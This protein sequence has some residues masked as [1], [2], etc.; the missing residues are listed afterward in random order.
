M[1]ELLQKFVKGR[2]DVIYLVFRVLIGGMFMQHGAQKILGAFGSEPAAMFSLFWIG[3]LVELIGGAAVL[4]GIL[5]RLAAL[6]S[7]IQMLVAYFMFH[8]TFASIDGLIPV[9]NKGELALVYFVS[10][11]VIFTW[12]AGKWSLEKMVTK[13]DEIF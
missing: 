4:L 3:G 13:K 10:F 1:S 5:T 9:L 11:L 2:E 8:A 12:G 7:T 6:L